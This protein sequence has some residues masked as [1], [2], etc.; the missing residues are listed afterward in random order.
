MVLL[1]GGIVL[2][3]V[4]VGVCWVESELC[5]FMVGC[6]GNFDCDGV[7]S[8]D[9]SIMDGDGCCGLVVVLIDI[10]YLVLVV[11]KVMENMLYVMLVG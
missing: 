4:E 5:N 1:V 8:L 7:F 2:D 11:C 9:V 10:L 3:V 6:C